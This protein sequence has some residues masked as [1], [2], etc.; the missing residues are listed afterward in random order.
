MQLW[1]KHSRCKGFGKIYNY[2]DNIKIR[3]KILFIIGITKDSKPK[4]IKGRFN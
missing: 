3:F 1:F 2:R 4:R